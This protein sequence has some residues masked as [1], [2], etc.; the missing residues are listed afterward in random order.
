[1]SLDHWYVYE[2]THKVIVLETDGYQIHEG[3]QIHVFF[4]LLVLINE[5]N[6]SFYNVKSLIALKK[7]LFAAVSANIRAQNGWINLLYER[8]SETRISEI[9]V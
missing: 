6:L 2:S 5:Q 8:L 7:Y 4:F 1:M 9:I 3:S